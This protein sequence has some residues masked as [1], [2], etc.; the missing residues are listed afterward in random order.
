MVR[1][2]SSPTTVTDSLYETLLKGPAESK[3]RAY[4]PVRI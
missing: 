1:E 3:G 2:E 4:V